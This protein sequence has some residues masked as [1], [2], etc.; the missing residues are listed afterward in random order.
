MLQNTKVIKRSQFIK[1]VY[2]EGIDTFL[3]IFTSAV[4]D[5]T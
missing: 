5:Q 4:E 3:F 2:E 1:E